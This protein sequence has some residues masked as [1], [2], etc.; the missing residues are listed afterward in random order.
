MDKP[1]QVSAAAPGSLAETLLP[2]DTQF[3]RQE[4]IDLIV[5]IVL[6]ADRRELLLLVGPKRSEEPYSREDEELL[7][8]VASSLALLSDEGSGREHETQNFL[9]CAQCGTCSD[10]PAS[11]CDHDASKLV[12]V[13]SPRVLASRYR[14]DR[15]IGRGGMGTV[16]AGTDTGLER[17]VA[18]KLIRSDLA[19]NVQAGLGEEQRPVRRW[20]SAFGQIHLRRDRLKSGEAALGI[21]LDERLA[22]I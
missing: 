2:A 13:E 17:P 4:G 15:R 5:P 1:L 11:R 3:L 8:T 18:V 16:Y 14:L 10:G 19:G 21:Q 12:R 9:E 20:Q 7:T 6:G 22:G